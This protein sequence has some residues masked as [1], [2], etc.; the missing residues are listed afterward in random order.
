MSQKRVLDILELELQVF[1]GYL[2]NSLLDIC[3]DLNSGSKDPASGTL[4]VPR[5]LS[6]P[7]CSPRTLPWAVAASLQLGGPPGAP[8]LYRTKWRLMS[9]KVGYSSSPGAVGK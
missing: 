6:S 7:E 8:H 9:A 3:Q 5:G 4:K 2:A 1:A